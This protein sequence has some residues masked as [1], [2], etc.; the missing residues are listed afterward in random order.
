MR[1][2]RIRRN[3][4]IVDSTLGKKINENINRIIEKRGKSKMNT[5]DTLLE[6]FNFNSDIVVS[7][8]RNLN[9]VIKSDDIVNDMDF[10]LDLAYSNKGPNSLGESNSKMIATKYRYL[11][12]SMVGVVDLNVSSNSD[13]GMSGSFVPYAEGLR[14]DNP[15]ADLLKYEKIEIVEK[16]PETI[17]RKKDTNES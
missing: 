14:K 3:E 5:M 8:M 10:I 17:T 16:E 11:H 1:N 15:Y 9:D 12:P 13:V 7:G 6:L 2:K 4:Y